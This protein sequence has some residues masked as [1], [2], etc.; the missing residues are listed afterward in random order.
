MIRKQISSSILTL[1]LFIAVSCL[2]DDIA[3]AGVNTVY[4]QTDTN[5]SD[6]GVPLDDPAADLGLSQDNSTNTTSGTSTNS[7]QTSTV[8]TPEFGGIAPIILMISVIS[9][10]ILTARTRLGFS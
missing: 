7:S 2:A 10:V 4:A 8:T 1:L 6:L 5:S 3:S 9:I